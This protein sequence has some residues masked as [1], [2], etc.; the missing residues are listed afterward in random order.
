MTHGD[1]GKGSA[2][3]PTNHDSFSKHFEEI[4]GRKP[5]KDV[6]QEVRNQ[7]IDAVNLASDP[8]GLRPCKKEN[9]SA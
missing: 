7:V 5:P 4:F 6:S 2:Q 8:A 1:G 3:R 9:P